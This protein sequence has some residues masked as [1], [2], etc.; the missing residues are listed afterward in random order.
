MQPEMPADK[1]WNQFSARVE[2]NRGKS[3][4]SRYPEDNFT[5][6]AGGRPFALSLI[7]KS[8]PIL[9]CADNCSQDRTPC[10]ASDDLSGYSAN[11]E[12]A[13]LSC[14]N[15]ARKHCSDNLTKNAA[16]DRPGNKISDRA[17]IKSWGCLPGTRTAK[18]TSHK[19]D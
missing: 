13:G 7:A 12:I 10:A 8:A 1:V 18:R 19:I 6:R 15:N 16:A 14:S 11:T 3:R 5:P 9:N 4:P 2:A 17:Q